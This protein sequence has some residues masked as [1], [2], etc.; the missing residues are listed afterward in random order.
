M[1]WIERRHG[2]GRRARLTMIKQGALWL[3]TTIRRHAMVGEWHSARTAAASRSQLLASC[4]DPDH[5]L[6]EMR[7]A[8]AEA[9]AILHTGELSRD[10]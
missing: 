6:Q 2:R 9:E 4:S 8:A 1:N 5:A 10:A 3:T 7:R